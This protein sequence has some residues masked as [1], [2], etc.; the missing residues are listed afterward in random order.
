MGPVPAELAKLFFDVRKGDFFKEQLA[1]TLNEPLFGDRN[2]S[3]RAV[4]VV[5]RCGES[6]AIADFHDAEIEVFINHVGSRGKLPGAAVFAGFRRREEFGEHLQARCFRIETECFRARRLLAE[7]DVLLDAS[8]SVSVADIRLE[9]VEGVAVDD[10]IVADDAAAGIPDL[11]NQDSLT[12]RGIVVTEAKNVTAKLLAIGRFH[13]D[14]ARRG[15]IAG[16][17]QFV[18]TTE[19]HGAVR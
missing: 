18:R 17:S 12:A 11:G 6:P 2:L 16:E 3:D 19:R 8:A 4:V 13:F 9:A 14:C 7:D 5:L 1:A 10:L 15:E